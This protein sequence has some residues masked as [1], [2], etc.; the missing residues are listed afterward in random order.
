MQNSEN[1]VSKFVLDLVNPSS[2]EATGTLEGDVQLL[3]H[4]PDGELMAPTM[5]GSGSPEV[6]LDGSRFQTYRF[7]V[8]MSH[9]PTD[10]VAPRLEPSESSMTIADLTKA[11]EALPLL[12]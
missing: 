6:P 4:V 8:P 7:L 2:L 3:I 11:I 10:H 1:R 12:N 5:V 9:V